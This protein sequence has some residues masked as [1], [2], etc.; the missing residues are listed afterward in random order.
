MRCDEFEQRWNEALDEREAPQ[1]IPALTAHAALC[2]HC[3]ALL[4]TSD[5]LT[6]AFPMHESAVPSLGWR[7]A[8]V[9]DVLQGLAEPTTEAIAVA[10]TMSSTATRGWYLSLAVATGLLI[11]IVASEALHRPAND[12][13]PQP[14]P[15]Q[16]VN[17]KPLPPAPPVLNK[18]SNDTPSLLPAT[19]STLALASLNR[20]QLSWVGYQVSDGL[21][22]VTMGVSNAWQTI[23]RPLHKSE[24]EPE[25][26]QP[27]E[28]GR[29]SSWT[30]VR[31]SYV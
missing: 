4:N 14:R 3:A 11:A 21:R 12:A 13:A 17:Q 26:P 18:T 5:L 10:R 28:N 7:E 22:P 20:Q 31:E 30:L 2:P 15:E 9:R 6:C 25:M 8:T 16:I 19:E 24:M 27:R 1:R 23:K 29:S